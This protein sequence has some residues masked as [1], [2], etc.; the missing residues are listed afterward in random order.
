MEGPHKLVSI[1]LQVR[2]GLAKLV[3]ARTAIARNNVTI[4]KYL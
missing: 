4:A 2:V 3:D 1:D